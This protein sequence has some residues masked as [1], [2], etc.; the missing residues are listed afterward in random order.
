M[1]S[2]DLEEPSAKEKPVNDYVS[3][4]IVGRESMDYG[5]VL[6]LSTREP[7]GCYGGSCRKDFTITKKETKEI[8][9]RFTGNPQGNALLKTKNCLRIS[10]EILPQ[11]LGVYLKPMD[12]DC[13]DPIV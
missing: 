11:V 8:N 9:A 13:L 10:R 7:V 6:L 4:S 5:K 2:G 12:S 1:L 3:F